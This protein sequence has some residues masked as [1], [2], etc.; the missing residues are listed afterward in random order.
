MS[1]HDG[2][3]PSD[4]AGGEDAS[5]DRDICPGDIIQADP[6]KT[7]YRGALMIVTGVTDTGVF[8]VYEPAF[9]TPSDAFLLWGSFHKT[10]GRPKFFSDRTWMPV[11]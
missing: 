3:V 7:R 1:A 10:G 5:P 2:P 11:N 9:S 4:T 8:A 6:H